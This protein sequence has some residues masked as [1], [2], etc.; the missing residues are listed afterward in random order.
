MTAIAQ[1]AEIS[2]HELAPTRS[3]LADW[4]TRIGAILR[5]L[6]PYAAI[7]ILLPGGTLMALLLWLYR[8]RAQGQYVPVLGTPT[9]VH[10]SHTLRCSTEPSPYCSWAT[11]AI[12]SR[13][14]M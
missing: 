3:R 12:F 6:G 2:R 13:P 5:Q 7:E 11:R 4:I 14:A 1:V 9:A 8:R 10:A